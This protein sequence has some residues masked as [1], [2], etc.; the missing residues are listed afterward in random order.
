MTTRIVC[1][2]CG[3][4]LRNG[5][6]GSKTEQKLCM[7]CV[8]KEYPQ[9]DPNKIKK[10]PSVSD[11]VEQMMKESRMK[12]ISKEKNLEVE[13]ETSLI[14]QEAEEGKKVLFVLNFTIGKIKK[15]DIGLSKEQLL[16]FLAD[17]ERAEVE[18]QIN[19]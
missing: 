16:A 8:Q 11:H 7:S 19:L 18:E 9:A 3:D 12:K 17:I 2:G 6:A 15:F 5:S 13:M 1:S 4:V 14:V 10:P